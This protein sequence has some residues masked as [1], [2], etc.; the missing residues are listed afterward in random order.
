MV[1]VPLIFGLVFVFILAKMLHDAESQLREEEHARLVVS[2]ITELSRTIQDG[3][4]ALVRYTATDDPAYLEQYNQIVGHSPEIFHNLKLL[5]KDRPRDFNTVQDLEQTT[6]V[7]LALLEKTKYAF[8]GRSNRLKRLKYVPKLYRAADR[9]KRR[10]DE[11][12]KEYKKVELS[13]PSAQERSR[14][15]LQRA[16]VAGLACNVL[17][18][19]ALAAFFTRGITTRL[20]TLSDNSLR[21]AREEPLNP[22]LGGS[23]E[24]AELDVVFHQVAETLAEARKKREEIEQLKQEFVAM[25]SHDL[26]APL[27]A[28]RATLSLLQEGTYGTLDDTGQSRVRAAEHNVNRLISLINDLLDIERMESGNLTLR[29]EE[30]PLAAIVEESID[31]VRQLAEQKRIEWDV[32][33]GDIDVQADYQRLVQVMV[34][35]LSNAIKFSPQGQKI[36]VSAQLNKDR[37]EVKVTDRG[38]GIP[39]SHRQA[40]FERFKQVEHAS[41]ESSGLGLAIARAIVQS[42]HGSIGVDSREGEGST[43][44]FKI[45]LNRPTS[46]RDH[47][48]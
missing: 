46:T 30:V 13:G 9:A 28:V 20:R 34:N 5:V 27:T 29:L 35:L 23:D 47:T 39:D 1:S 45:P 32:A 22:L 17:V 11:I 10:I 36:T 15:V 14:Q 31:S 7:A 37:A 19:L 43:F 6:N 33:V 4:V 26:R 16:L 24:I 48:G 41:R 40:I 12:V 18:A 44:W 8:G 42:H 21:L 25:I 38:P 2:H 3:A